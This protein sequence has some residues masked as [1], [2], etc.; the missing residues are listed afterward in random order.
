MAWIRMID[1]EDAAGPLRTLYEAI[2]GGRRRMAHILKVQSLH[3]DALR[4]HYALY[5]T[6]MF[7]HSPLSRAERESIAVAVSAA[8]GCHYL[9][10]CARSSSTPTGSPVRPPGCGRRTWTRCAPSASTTAPFWMSYR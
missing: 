9:T 2:A 4:D 3:A 1:E 7:G 6:L 5:R 10:G 8:N